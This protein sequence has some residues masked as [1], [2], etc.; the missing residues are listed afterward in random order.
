M[1]LGLHEELARL[2][3]LGDRWAWWELCR[4]YH[5][6]LRGLAGKFA[7]RTKSMTFDDLYQESRIVLL[8]LAG[9]YQPD[10]GVRFSTFLIG[11]GAYRLQRAID[12]QDRIIYTPAD[13]TLEH[14]NTV[15]SGGDS[16]LP[17]AVDIDDLGEDF[18]SS[19]LDGDATDSVH[20]SALA[21]E[22]LR[23]AERLTDKEKT[24]LA[25][26]LADE[27]TFEEIGQQLGC[28]RQGAINIYQ[29]AIKRI[30]EWLQVDTDAS[31]IM[32]VAPRKRKFHD[33]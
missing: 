5:H 33:S 21:T 16:Y 32:P 4:E 10:R 8:E 28:T 29:R 12:G 9:R 13:H 3:G 22:V 18:V 24:V 11:Y 1:V 25:M 26:Y 6:F 2:A 7:T 23:H 31:P 20:K 27:A 30:R 17:T 15:R 19:W 14:R